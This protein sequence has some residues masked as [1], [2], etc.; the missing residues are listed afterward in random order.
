MDVGWV[1]FGLI[2]TTT[3]SSAQAKGNSY[4]TGFTEWKAGEFT[5][6]EISGT[7]FGSGGE[8]VLDY[9]S[10]SEGT[11]PFTTGADYG[12]NFYNAGT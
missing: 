8:I 1:D 9:T 10:A 2:F 4:M 5:E 7:A 6:W 12:R 11:D 3:T